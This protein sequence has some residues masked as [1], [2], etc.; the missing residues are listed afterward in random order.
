MLISNQFKL[1]LSKIKVAQFNKKK[2]LKLKLFSVVLPLLDILWGCGIIYGYSKIK[3]GYII[4]L[5][6]SLRGL[7]TLNSV[8]FFYPILTKNQLKTLLTINPHYSYLVLTCKG[9]SIRLKKNLV[10]YG[11][12]LIAKL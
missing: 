7:G 3:N 2:I 9:I 8:A 5:K 6:Y 1:L 10:Q 12:I 4:F 11:G